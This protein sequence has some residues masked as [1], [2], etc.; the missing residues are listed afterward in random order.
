MEWV[1]KPQEK[2]D[3]EIDLFAECGC[4]TS[5]T[6]YSGPPCPSKTCSPIMYWS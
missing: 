1:L 4:R 6:A 3:E 2:T 5:Y